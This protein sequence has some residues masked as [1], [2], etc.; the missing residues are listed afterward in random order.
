MQRRKGSN[1]MWQS[2]SPCMH[3][4]AKGE[5][6]F[7]PQAHSRPNALNWAYISPILKLNTKY[8]SIFILEHG[9]TCGPKIKAILMLQSCVLSYFDVFFSP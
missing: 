5:P 2:H 8:F 7:V 3:Q 1:S 9:L 6:S 4:V